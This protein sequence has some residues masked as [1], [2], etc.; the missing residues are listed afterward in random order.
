MLSIGKDKFNNIEKSE[1]NIQDINKNY[2]DIKKEK[3]KLE[4]L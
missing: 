3:E 4:E 1:L 2:D